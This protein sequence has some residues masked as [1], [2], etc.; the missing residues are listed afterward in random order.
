MSF[1][2]DFWHWWIGGLVLLILEVFLPG[3]F[4]LWMGVAAG[5][6][7][8]LV[9]I[10]PAMP[11][12]YQIIVFAV[13]SVVNIVAWKR[14]EK[15]RPVRTDQPALNRRGE[16]YVGRR[17]TL[18]DPIVNGVGHLR[19]DDTRWRIEGPDLPAGR[20]VVVT[21]VDGTVLRVEAAG[22]NERERTYKRRKP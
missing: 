21:G 1:V 16:Q 6:V 11:I 8:V 2:P 5:F 7:G 10:W 19:V 22:G 18:D 17:F 4:F 12:E 14:Y 15:R 20:K 9:W 3:T 13:D